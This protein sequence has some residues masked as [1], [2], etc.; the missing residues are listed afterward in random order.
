MMLRGNAAS[1]EPKGILVVHS[2][3]DGFRPL[4][5]RARE[6]G[7]L[8]VS[9][10]TDDDDDI[11]A[12]TTMAAAG[13]L[14]G[15]DVVLGPLLFGR[16]WRKKKDNDDP[17]AADRGAAAGKNDVDGAA[18]EDGEREGR[19]AK[20]VSFD[21]PPSWPSSASSQVVVGNDLATMHA[22]SVS[23]AGFRFMSK[24]TVGETNSHDF[25]LENN[26]ENLAI[27]RLTHGPAEATRFP[28]MGFVGQSAKRK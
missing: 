9:V 6:R 14:R 15:S 25:L 2:D 17:A 11:A 13:L 19:A 18:G 12:P 3:D 7:F 28:A 8:A 23:D 16:R 10:V 1:I 26:E 24:R 4:L 22:I 27:W 21:A 20:E 5:E